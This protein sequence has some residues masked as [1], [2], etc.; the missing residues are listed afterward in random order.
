MEFQ[1][2]PQQGA[3]PPTIQL[4]A[5]K[6]QALTKEVKDLAAKE[7]IQSAQPSREG[8]TS[9]LF[10]VQVR[11]VMAPSHQP[12]SP[13]QICDYPSLQDGISENS[14]GNNAG[15]GLDDKAGFE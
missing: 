3:I 10:L 6:A 12:Q 11:W 7:A 15:G 9:P 14:E 8:F 1:T 5:Q 2:S 13:K 4:D